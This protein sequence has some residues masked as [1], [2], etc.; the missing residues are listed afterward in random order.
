[1]TG[2]ALVVGVG[3]STGLGGLLL[4]TLGLRP[5]P[6]V[7]AGSSSGFR[8][9]GA[10][11]RRAGLGSL[12]RRRLA[13]WGGAAAVGVA[14]WAVSGWPVAGVLAAVGVLGVP[15][16][17]GAA[18][19]AQQRIGR[20]EALEEWVRRLADAM[21]AGSAPVQTIV[22][23]ADRAP[24]PIRPA[25]AQLASRLSTPRLNRQVALRAFAADLDDPLGDM[26]VLA[27]DIA[28]S[29]QASHKVPDVLRTI[30]AE[31]SDE[32]RARRKVEV[33]RAEPR[34]EARTIVVIQVLFVAAVSVF[35]SYTE[36]YG[37]VTGQLILA[38][39]GAVVVFALWL[40][41]R[42][43]LGDQPPRLLTDPP[44]A[45]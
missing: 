14:V 31:V 12:P 42:F 32:V 43:G 8:T 41:R 19:I 17:F 13:R 27:L 1:M 44:V 23:S 38:G 33:D 3:V 24:A 39:F 21:G 34:N 30:A 11:V 20:L 22:R 37:T 16:F 28:V 35:T 2:Y 10:R 9:P 36:V 29:A 4:I 15:Y 45:S 26:V 40:L 18:R 25:V 5:R 7:T 6:P